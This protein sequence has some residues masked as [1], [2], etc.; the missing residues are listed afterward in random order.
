VSTLDFETRSDIARIALSPNG[1]LLLAVDVDGHA[2]AVNL[3]RRVVVHRINFKGP[4]QDVAFSPDGRFFVVGYDKGVFEVF[5]VYDNEGAFFQLECVKLFD[6]NR[7]FPVQCIRF[8]PD[9]R[10][11]VITCN[12]DIVVFN[13]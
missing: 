2:L 5:Q 13:G 4:V 6:L 11:L 12:K 8:T 7:E 1:R 10:F 9:G 3:P